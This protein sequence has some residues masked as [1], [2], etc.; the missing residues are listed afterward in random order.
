MIQNNSMALL[1]AESANE[2]ATLFNAFNSIVGINGATVVHSDGRI[3]F[4]LGEF[5]QGAKPTPIL[6]MIQE[7]DTDTYLSATKMNQMLWAY[8]RIMSSTGDGIIEPKL[9]DGGIVIDVLL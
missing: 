3:Q 4:L 8:N 1:S 9:V 5:D 7:G 2:I 6:E